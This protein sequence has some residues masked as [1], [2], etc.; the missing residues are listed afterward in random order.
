METRLAFR[1]CMEAFARLLIVAGRMKLFL[2]NL[3]SGF[4]LPM[5]ASF[6]FLY[7]AGYESLSFICPESRNA[8]R[9]AV[10]LWSW[11]YP[12]DFSIFVHWGSCKHVPK[13]HARSF[14]L[15]IEDSF[16]FQYFT[17]FVDLI[18]MK[19]Y[20]VLH[21]LQEYHLHYC[22]SQEL[23]MSPQWGYALG[24][25][26]PYALTL[27]PAPEYHLS[28]YS[29]KDMWNWPWWRFALALDTPC[30]SG[31]SMLKNHCSTFWSLENRRKPAFHVG[32]WKYFVL[33]KSLLGRWAV[34]RLGPWPSQGWLSAWAWCRC[35][36]SVLALSNGLSVSSLLQV[37]WIP[38][39]LLAVQF[40]LGW[41]GGI[42]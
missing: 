36:G 33:G 31:I 42:F 39:S 30:G 27:A 15:F 41:G 3:C 8:R 32:I 38:T 35:W 16:P 9:S 24:S 6:R 20:L 23:P 34:P 22:T 10:A 17:A 21:Q 13:K 1:L 5:G 2:I 14:R 11:P 28:S 25:T 4:G 37:V 7:N 29:S 12:G 26:P 19:E 18:L 40:I